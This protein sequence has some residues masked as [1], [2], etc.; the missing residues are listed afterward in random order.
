MITGAPPPWG[1]ID[2]SCWEENQAGKKGRGR[3]RGKKRM[4]KRKGGKNEKFFPLPFHNLDIC[5]HQL[6]LLSLLFNIT[7]NS[8]LGK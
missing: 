8:T 7:L 2:S 4:G 6:V 3:E 5:P 1:G